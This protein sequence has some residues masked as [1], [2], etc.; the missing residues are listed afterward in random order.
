M[1]VYSHALIP[2][3]LAKTKLMLIITPTYETM[4]FIPK[5]RGVSAL[6]SLK[7]WMIGYNTCA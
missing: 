6:C 4:Q 7:W 3:I 1:D 2:N 5:N